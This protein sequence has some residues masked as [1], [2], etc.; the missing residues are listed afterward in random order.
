M[1]QKIKN[2]KVLHILY[3][4]LEFIIFASLILYVLAISFQRFSNNRAIFGYRVFTVATGSMEPAYEVG[5]VILV[6]ETIPEEL[7]VGDVIT[8]LGNRSSVS[9]IIIT[10]RIINIETKSDGTL[11][12]TVKGDANQVEDPV[13][14]SSQIYGKVTMKLTFITFISNIVHNQYGFFFLIFVPIVL[15]IFLE[16]ADTIMDMREEKKRK[17][18]GNADA[19]KEE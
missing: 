11:S 16:V 17:D 14:D 6:K 9:G 8:Y 10:H 5:D 2:N 7:Q 1:I 19:S 3:R 13:I 15:F 4:T 18:E 12:F